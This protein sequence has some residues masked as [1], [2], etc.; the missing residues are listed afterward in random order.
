MNLD[1]FTRQYI[2]TA[3]WSTHDESTPSGGEPFDAN[4]DIND[5][6][7][8]TM[9]KIVQDCKKFQEENANDIG[10][11]YED[12]GHDFLLTRNGHGCGFF[13]IP[14]WEEQIGERLTDAAHKFGEFN[15][16][17]GDDGL[18]YGG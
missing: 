3:L 7:P 9:T 1:V 17:V 2:E 15:L 16:Y 14:D 8:D 11:R 10:D 12:A 13:E 4:Y 18:I 5:I 6:H